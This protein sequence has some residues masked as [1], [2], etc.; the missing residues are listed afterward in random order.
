[1]KTNFGTFPNSRVCFQNETILLTLLFPYFNQ[2]SHES[3]DVSSGAFD[4]K[5]F[6]ICRTKKNIKR[7][8]S[9]QEQKNAFENAI[10]TWS[11]ENF[12]IHSTEAGSFRWFKFETHTRTN[13]FLFAETIRQLKI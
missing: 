3:L 8:S 10:R 9:K 12:Q 7:E 11:W 5:V 13:S 2:S 6:R 4:F 1:M